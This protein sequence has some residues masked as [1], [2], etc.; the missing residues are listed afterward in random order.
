VEAIA[1]AP[2]EAQVVDSLDLV[3]LRSTLGWRETPGSAIVKSHGNFNDMKVRTS[4]QSGAP[5]HHRGRCRSVVQIQNCLA[6]DR[7]APV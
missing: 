2:G 7:A 3:A 4:I 1:D 5:L 6:V